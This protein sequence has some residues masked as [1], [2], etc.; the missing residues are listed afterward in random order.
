MVAMPR[1]A[2]I[3]VAVAIGG[4]LLAGV[5]LFPVDRWAL[6]LVA[7]I[8]GAGAGGVAA[9]AVAYIAATVL[10]LPGSVLT[11]GAGF[12]YGPAL[13]L[14]L[15][16]PVSVVAATAAFSLGR[17]IARGW[18][19]RKVSGDP[20]FAAIDEAVGESG[21]KIVF[22]LR[23]SPV[24][25]FNLLNFTLGLTR[26]RLRDYVAAS[27]LGMLPGTLLYV[28]LG[29]LVTSASELAAGRGV[30]AGSWQKALYVAGL[31]ATV[32]ATVVITR[33]ARQALAR[34]LDHKTAVPAAREIHT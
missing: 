22:L 11:L 21:F 32:A 14:L 24:L 13:G 2:R 1:W 19:A 10:L 30:S 6:A 28:Y 29:S 34:A 25:P 27:F 18:V 8:R 23:L 26:V 15:V 7:W 12:A 4:A 31:V 16:S 20:R 3:I 17:S 33:V 9:F 5:L